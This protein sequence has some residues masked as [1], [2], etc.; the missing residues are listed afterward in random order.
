LLSLEPG[1]Y[2]L[3]VTDA[4]GCLANFSF[5]VELASGL[6]DSSTIPWR[7]FPNPTAQKVYVELPAGEPALLR[8]FDGTGRLVFAQKSS[9][10][11]GRYAINLEQ[12]APGMYWVQVITEDGVHKG[13]KR[14]IVR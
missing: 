6:N 8:F 11:A 1:F 12:L 4:N 7:L 2:S 14:L 5:E 3:S 9:G 10:G 13:V